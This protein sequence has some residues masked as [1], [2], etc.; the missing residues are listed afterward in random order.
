MPRTF[1]IGD[2]QG[3]FAKVLEVLAAHGALAGD[4]LAPDVVLVSIGD[5]FD[6]DQHDPET[7]GKEGVR[8]LRWLADHHPE[9]GRIL[10]A[11][12]AAEQARLRLGNHD[13]SRVM[14]LIDFDDAAFA[15]A[16]TLARG[17]DD[18]AF[19]AA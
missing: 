1:V 2:P 14:E 7:A 4:R 15:A 3:P 8:L 10:P 9:P 17:G 6:Y 19:A 18:K 16:R 5:H 13:A 12:P 11:D